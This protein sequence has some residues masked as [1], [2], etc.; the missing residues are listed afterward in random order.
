MSTILFNDSTNEE[1]LEKEEKSTPEKP[2]EKEGNSNMTTIVLIV[3]IG[4]LV[5]YIAYTNSKK[6]D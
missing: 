6:E 2:V 4:C 1:L 5:A 3:L